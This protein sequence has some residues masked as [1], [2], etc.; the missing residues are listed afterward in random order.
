MGSQRGCQGQAPGAFRR[1]L[2]ESGEPSHAEVALLELPKPSEEEVPA[3][4]AADADV[5]EKKSE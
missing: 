1:M 3:A 2:D 4:A 5:A